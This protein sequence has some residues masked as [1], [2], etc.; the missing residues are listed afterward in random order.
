MIRLGASGGPKKVHTDT[1]RP[2]KALSDP[3]AKKDRGPS[4]LFDDE[5]V[6]PPET[7]RSETLFR[8]SSGSNRGS[9]DPGS[10]DQGSTESKRR[11]RKKKKKSTPNRGGSPGGDPDSGG[12]SDSDR[13]SGS[14]GS[15]GG[16]VNRH[17]VKALSRFVKWM[18][19]KE[20]N[21][22]HSSRSKRYTSSV[23]V[24]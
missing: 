1:P 19:R 5:F 14:S 4:E 11:R 24:L 9:P 22:C 21:S 3:G 13:S 18:D 23:V 7:R 20:S 8:H 2:G 6:P 10:S 12:G 16:D 15:G 17:M